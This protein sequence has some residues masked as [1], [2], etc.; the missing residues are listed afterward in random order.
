MNLKLNILCL[1][2]VVKVYLGILFSLLCVSDT[3]MQVNAAMFEQNGGSGYVL[4]PRVMWDKR[5][6]MYGKFNPWD[7]DSDGLQATTLTVQ[8]MT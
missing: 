3:A 1:M 4:K 7:K 8:V 5:H 6:V 2:L